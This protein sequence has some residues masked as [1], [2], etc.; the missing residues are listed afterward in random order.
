MMAVGTSWSW[1]PP[2][3]GSI[4]EG[5]L[6]ESGRSRARM[7]CANRLVEWGWAVPAP[8]SALA[9]A[10]LDAPLFSLPGWASAAEPH[11]FGS[12]NLPPQP[13]SS[14]AALLLMLILRRTFGVESPSVRVHVKPSLI[15]APARRLPSRVL[16]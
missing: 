10:A 2:R 3:G 8:S 13:G 4:V 7:P 14:A 6:V 12:L 5:N 11:E 15:G 9:L 1:K 16:P